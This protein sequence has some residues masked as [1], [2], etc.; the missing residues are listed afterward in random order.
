M[1][2]N[3]SVSSLKSRKL[4]SKLHVLMERAELIQNR[5]ASNKQMGG[6]MNFK[7]SKFS[8]KTTHSFVMRPLVHQIQEFSHILIYFF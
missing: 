1:S 8:P 2:L 3:E 5:L 6:E 4:R 7:L